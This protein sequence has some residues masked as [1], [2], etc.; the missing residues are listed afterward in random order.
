[1]ANLTSST[2]LHLVR[3][4]TGANVADPGIQYGFVVCFL[5]NTSVQSGNFTISGDVGSEV[6]VGIIPVNATESISVIN[7]YQADNGVGTNSIAANVSDSSLTFYR[8]EVDTGLNAY[9]VYYVIDFENNSNA[10]VQHIN[11]TAPGL[12]AA[13]S[14]TTPTFNAVDTTKTLLNCENTMANGGGT[15]YTRGYWAFNLTSAANA[16]YMIEGRDRSDTQ[17]SDV[18]CQ[19]AEWP[20]LSTMETGIG[21]NDTQESKDWITYTDIDA[22]DISNIALITVTVDVSAYG[23]AGSIENSNTAADL[24]VELARADEASW[25]SI[26]T[27]S[28]S[29]PGTY[30]LTT[31]DN[32]ILSA[33]AY[34]DFRDI[35]AQGIYMDY[36]NS[37]HYDYIN[38]TSLTVNISYGEATSTWL[39]EWTDTANV[40]TYNVTDIYATDSIEINH[41]TLN[42]NFNVADT[43]PPVIS[44][45]SNVTIQNNTPLGVQYIATDESGIDNW[46][47]NDSQFSINSSG[48]LVNATQLDVGVYWLN[49]SVNDTY[50]NSVW[51][52]LWINV[53]TVPDTNSPWFDPEL[54]NQTAEY[55]YSFVYDTDAYDD[56]GVVD[57]Y[58]VNDTGNFVMDPSTG[59]LSNKTV[60]TI[61]DY[62]INISANDTSGNVNWT[63]IKVSVADTKAPFFTPQ[64]PNITIEYTSDFSYDVN[65]TDY[66]GV[67]RYWIDDTENFSINPISGLL[68]NNTLLDTINYTINV[69]VNDTYGNVNWS[70]MIIIV[71]DTTPPSTINGLTDI[72]QGYDWI[73]W[74]WTNPT[75]PDFSHTELWI[76]STF[77]ANITST[78]YNATGLTPSTQFE[79]QITTVDEVGNKNMTWINDSASTLQ[80]TEP[81]ASINYPVNNT[82]FNINSNDII[83]NVTLF[84]EE[85]GTLCVKI[86]GTN[87]TII[88]DT[89]MLYEQCGLS[90]GT[91]VTYN[92]TSPVADSGGDCIY[93]FDNQ[94]KYGESNTAINDYG[95]SCNDGTCSGG[96]CPTYEM[97]SGKFA[98]S[99]YYDGGD[100][101]N[102]GATAIFDNVFTDRTMEIW[103]KANI[104]S[105]ATFRTI[106]EEGGGTNGLN[107]YIYDDRVWAGYWLAGV[108]RWINFTTNVDEWHYLGIIFD[109]NDNFT[110]VYDDQWQSYSMSDT[111]LSHSGDNFVG[112]AGTT[113]FHTAG[114]STGFSGYLDDFVVY[115]ETI[116]GTGELLDHYRLGPSVYKWKVNV[117]DQF[118]ETE[119]KRSDFIV[120]DSYQLFVGSANGTMDLG[121]GSSTMKSI[122][123]G[124]PKN[125]YY[126]DF[127]SIFA[128]DSLQAVG[129][130]KDGTAAS[131]D[132]T[133]LDSILLMSGDF[134]APSEFWSTDGSTPVQTRDIEIFGAAIYNVPIVNSIQSESFVTGI[135]WDMDD[136]ADNELDAGEGEDI[137]FVAIY[138]ESKPGKFGTYGYE[139]RIPENLAT[140]VAPSDFISFY[141]EVD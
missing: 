37:T 125:L 89:D 30:T 129:R 14:Y 66:T 133:E 43:K 28:I 63:L 131:N 11:F 6:T 96:T 15:A 67:H 123:I 68:Q 135:L 33:W 101:W 92:W 90:N 65:A 120:S 23:N 119:S 93:K 34:P 122:G 2:N 121:Y 108:G 97:G 74:S 88:L 94:S 41:T 85:L 107:I 126:A 58:W 19:I 53:T 52:A 21:L 32:S 4:T 1:M 111:M 55:N 72:S 82:Y 99:H 29:G 17:F 50:S 118:Y 5:D 70:L 91:T 9:G 39:Y 115:S 16:V 127:D 83:L 80:N 49:I 13:L 138:N 26:G 12:G 87:E 22:T 7:W 69:S 84:D 130:R 95:G 73:Y 40:G 117:S 48:Y 57:I 35:R 132:F 137:L 24:H 60:L 56:Y 46:N 75:E 8:D 81:N 104:T 54:E 116:L 3:D 102:L 141:L 113:V 136:S 140:Y 103:F 112:D 98:G 61:G 64:L 106:F 25:R 71:L 86:F 79:I 62:I 139:A 45:I 36:Y 51:K 76:N 110:M 27:F 128:W 20:S 77:F 105:G 59:I 44:F 38:Y 100:N 18:R 10:N 109:G 42:L 134:D 78:A 47:V 114:G 31:T 124:Q